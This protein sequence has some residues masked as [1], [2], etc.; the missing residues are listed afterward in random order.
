MSRK[1]TARV[2]VWLI[3]GPEDRIRRR[4]LAD[5]LAEIGVGPQDFDLETHGGDGG[6]VS[7]WVASAGTAPFLAPARVVLVRHLL[8]AGDPKDHRIDELSSVP[9]SGRLILVA[10]EEATLDEDRQRRFSDSAKA[11]A[12]AVTSA[13]GT[14]IEASVPP[15]QFSSRLRSEAEAL[16][17]SLSATAADQ[18]K[19]LCGGSF[20]RAL[21]EVEKLALYVGDRPAIAEADVHKAASASRE[22]NVFRLVESIAGGEAGN[23]FA[24]LRVL[25]GNTSKPDDVA[26][27]FLPS[28]SRQFR[29]VWQARA[30][31]DARV[32]PGEMGTRLPGA[33]AD[34]PRLDKEPDFVQQ[35]AL[36]LAKRL[37][38]TAIAACLQEVAD[39]DARLKGLR[40]ATSAMDS[41]E[42]MV[43]RC[44]DHTSARARD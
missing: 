18:L 5:L 30:A 12:R 37:P 13:G 20:S 43:V 17:K 3:H 36:R 29:L 25:F 22:H 26:N 40:P 23:A 44:L 1:A 32:A 27:R 38:L 24:Q 35:K 21:D 10:D 31:L 39:C 2:P 9:D 8:R 14:V 7:D 6:K 41:V 33:L 15:A 4:A 16:G 19:E 28:L 11:W 42:T 34:R